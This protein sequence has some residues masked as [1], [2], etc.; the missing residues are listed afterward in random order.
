MSKRSYPS[1]ARDRIKASLVIEKLNRFVMGE[2]EMSAHQ[3]NAA[4][5]LLN[6]VLPDLK[7]VEHSGEISSKPAR[8]LDNAEISAEIARYQEILRAIEGGEE[9]GT[10]TDQPDSL[11]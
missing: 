8:K 10:G 7:A 5:I 4:R 9:A 2:C 1:K 6:K 3:V 11:H